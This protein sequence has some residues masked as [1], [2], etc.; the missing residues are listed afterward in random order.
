MGLT[1]YLVSFP[2]SPQRPL[3]LGA[4]LSAT[5][6]LLLPFGAASVPGL[7]RL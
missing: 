5:P 4:L 1:S 7:G 3:S 6:P 2:S